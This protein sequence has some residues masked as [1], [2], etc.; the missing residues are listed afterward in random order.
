PEAHHIIDVMRMKVGDEVVV[1][2]GTGKEYYGSIISMD[3][4]NQV[5]T[6][7]V[8]NV[9]AGQSEDDPIIHLVQAIPKKDKMDNIV[10]KATELGVSS[11]IPVV[12]DRTIVR[13][14]KKDSVKKT[15]RWRKLATVAAK[16]CGR[17]TIP[18]IADIVTYRE[19]L[20]SE[21]G[22]YAMIVFACL[23]DGTMPLK[24]VIQNRVDGVVAVLVGPEGDFTPEE[25]N[26]TVA[27]GERVRLVSLGKRVLKSD[28]AGFFMI[29]ALNYEYSE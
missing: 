20:S 12:T 14:D 10:E 18:Y 28:T 22:R 23:A 26:A 4:K 29:S 5:L 2:D 3:A 21:R 27:L 9:T 7:D 11:I 25:M 17:A 8:K 15:E 1:F 24:K 16:Q 19:F 13:P 6:V